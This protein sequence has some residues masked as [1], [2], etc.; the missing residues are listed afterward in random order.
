MRRSLNINLFRAHRCELID[1]KRLILED[2]ARDLGPFSPVQLV[3]GDKVPE[4]GVDPAYP[5][6][7]RAM[8]R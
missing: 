7:F 2:G 6:R 3:K 5:R 4:N 1:A 8:I